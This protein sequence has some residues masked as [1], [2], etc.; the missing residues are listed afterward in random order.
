MMTIIEAMRERHSVRQYQ[1]LPIEEEKVTFIKDEM[2]KLSHES[3]LKFQLFTNEPEAFNG[4]EPHYGHFVA[5][6]NYM[7]ISGP[8]AAAEACGYYGEQLVLFCQMLGLNTCWVALT[9]KK[10]AIKLDLAKGEKL[11]IVISLGYGVT[12]GMPHKSKRA[13]QVSN[14]SDESPDWFKQGVEAALLAPTAINQQQ[15]YLELI[16][17]ATVKAKAKIG[18]CNKIDLGIVKYHFEVGAGRDNFTWSA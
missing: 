15:F 13:N 1:D 4:N 3:G 7:T 18:P 5:C 2:E 10:S 6:K 17:D 9:F 11:L 12:P 14:I 16:D 8:S